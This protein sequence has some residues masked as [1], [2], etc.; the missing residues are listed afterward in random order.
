MI[1]WNPGGRRLQF[2]QVGR[3]LPAQLRLRRVRQV[4]GRKRSGP[5]QGVR[6]AGN[7]LAPGRPQVRSG[8]GPRRRGAHRGLRPSVWRLG[9]RRHGGHGALE[10]GGTPTPP[11]LQEGIR[12]LCHGATPLVSTLRILKKKLTVFKLILIILERYMHIYMHHYMNIILQ[13]YIYVGFGPT[14]SL[15]LDCVVHPV[16]ASKL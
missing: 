15:G 14:P 4:P 3:V 13:I 11:D 10:T 1:G 7:G 6:L 2:R 12:Q 5:A 9:G 8:P 16:H